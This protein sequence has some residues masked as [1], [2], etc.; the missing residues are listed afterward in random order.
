MVHQMNLFAVQQPPEL[1]IESSEH[2]CFSSDL[3]DSTFGFIQNNLK[4]NSVFILNRAKHL[5]ET[6]I[7]NVHTQNSHSV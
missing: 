5:R 2:L 4:N 1:F 6:W 7:H 3:A